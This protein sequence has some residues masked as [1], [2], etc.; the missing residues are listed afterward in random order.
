MRE[1]GEKEEGERE[2][3]RGYVFKRY[4]HDILIEESDKKGLSA[5]DY[6]LGMTR[7]THTP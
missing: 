3:V 5:G 7:F 1:G 4:I 2:R 6:P